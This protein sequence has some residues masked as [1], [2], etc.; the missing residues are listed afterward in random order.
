MFFILGS[1]GYYLFKFGK[2]LSCCLYNNCSFPVPFSF[3]SGT[4]ITYTLDFLTM[5]H[6]SLM[7]YSVLFTL[8]A[9]LLSF[10]LGFETTMTTINDLVFEYTVFHMLLSLSNEFL[11]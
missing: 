10:G 8:L 4:S 9:S 1:V 2:I 6:M 3:P 5:S 11:S 7:F